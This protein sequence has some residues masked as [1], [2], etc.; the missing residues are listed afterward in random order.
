M[1]LVAELCS[2]GLNLGFNG[3]MSTSSCTEVA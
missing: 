2:C 1:A 3:M